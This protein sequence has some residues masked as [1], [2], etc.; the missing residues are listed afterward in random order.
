LRARR[1]PPLRGAPTARRN[2]TYSA[3]TGYVYEYFY[4][5]WR[6]AARSG[7]RG[8]QYVF[9]ASADRR[10]YSPVSVFLKD[11]AIESWE[12]EH[13]R[14][15]NAAE[16]YGL[17]KMALFQAFDERESPRL[18]REEVVVRPADAGD[19]LERLGIW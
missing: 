3:Q 4:E 10:N 14:E 2:K 19:I 12:R 8:S 1:L 11:S 17:A 16:R 7:E 18:M 9:Q 13:G 15:L 5:G 6:P